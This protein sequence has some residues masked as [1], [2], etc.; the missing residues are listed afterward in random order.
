MTKRFG[1][2]SSPRLDNYAGTVA[3]T[4]ND[5]AADGYD[6][7]SI[8]FDTV[9]QNAFV[10]V[11]ATTTAAV[12]KLITVS[13][14]GAGSV[15]F[16]SLWQATANSQVP[17]HLSARLGLVEFPASISVARVTLR[18][19]TTGAAV[20]C[21]FALYS[22]DGQTKLIDVTG[23]GS[24]SA[25]TD[26][27]IAVSPAVYIARGYYY[28]FVCRNATTGS[29]TVTCYATKD[30]ALSASPAGS[31]PALHGTLVIVGGAAPA[32]ITPSAITVTDSSCPV[33]RFDNA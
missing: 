27:S 3:P 32:T 4:A 2:I 21:R 19:G 9:L 24:A 1:A 10:C 29:L 5:D 14:V 6:V 18:Q 23:N 22:F 20:S 31:L 15:L 26:F 30:D 25:N 8:W 12:W 13:T 28:A 11:D 7:G 33:C 16:P 17:T